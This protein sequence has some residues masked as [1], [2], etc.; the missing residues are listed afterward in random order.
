MEPKSI[1]YSS[2]ATPAA[3]RSYRYA[4]R[5]CRPCRIVWCPP[6][7]IG[8]TVRSAQQ[9]D[10]AQRL[11]AAGLNDCAVARQLG[12]PRSTIR[13]WRCRPQRQTRPDGTTVCGVA[14]DFAALAAIPYCSYSACISVTGA[15][16]GTVESG[17]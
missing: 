6:R 11:M 10:A 9:F 16:H 15:S 14:H 2:S 17:G 8:D 1:A 13:E 5:I 4:F 7:A 3:W 12:I